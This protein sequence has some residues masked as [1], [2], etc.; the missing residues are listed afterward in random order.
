M[1]IDIT[2]AGCLAGTFSEV[3]YPLFAAMS[4]TKP[5]SGFLRC[6]KPIRTIKERKQS[7]NGEFDKR[8]IHSLTR[9]EAT[10]GR[11]SLNPKP[12]SSIAGR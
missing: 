5:L 7:W 2:P 8:S 10:L 6:K 11:F 4:I 12:Q 3:F 1:F 9:V